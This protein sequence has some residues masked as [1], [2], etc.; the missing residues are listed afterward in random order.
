MIMMFEKA[1]KPLLIITLALVFG[2]FL[3]LASASMA[4][5]QNN[6]GAIGYYTLRQL[7]YGGLGGAILLL[8]VSAF[9][10]RRLRKLA[11]PLMLISFL[12]LALLFI[13]DLSYASGG[14]RRWLRIGTASFQPSEFLK[15]AF[16]IYLA[17]WL[18][19]RRKDVASFSYG[20]L[21]FA[22]MLAVVGLFL[23]MQPDIG[24]L[25]VI[26]A[27]AGLL[28]FLGGGRISQIATLG[29]FG[30]LI[31]YFII[32]LA[33]YRLERIFVFLNPGFDPEGAGYQISQA[34]IAIGTGGFFGRGFGKSIQK[35]QYLPEPMGDSIFAIYAEE[36][37]FLG[38]MALIILFGLFLWRGF[39]I[40]ERA[41]DIFGKLLAAGITLSITVQAFI[42]MAAISG[43]LP[44][45]GI[46]LPFV[47]YGGTSLA[48]TLTSI[49]ILMNISKHT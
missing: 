31:L 10:Y 26:A 28:Y 33:P 9:P 21:P 4:L 5:A 14:A 32:Q 43:L 20:M 36:L 8:A 48:M 2:G 47:S 15:L 46:P 38:A 49:G 24:T 41:P 42:N 35:Y 29:A 13:P 12:M 1:D 11:L 34:S 39:R 40:A 25:G 3:I 45:T 6:F 37:G 30:L 17:S 23:V 18:D 7:L 19:A 44:L 27:T 22:L 16:V